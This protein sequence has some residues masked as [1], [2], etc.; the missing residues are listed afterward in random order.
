[1]TPMTQ[2]I[3]L[4]TFAI[5][6]GF[7]AQAA[8]PE[9]TGGKRG[10]ERPSFE[11]LDANK[12]GQLTQDELMAPMTARFGTMDTNGDGELSSDE[13][14]A[15]G[16][17]RAKRRADKMIERLDADKNGTISADEMKTRMSEGRRGK[18]FERLDA[19]DNG[20]ISA[21]EFA[22]IEKRMGKKGGKHGKRKMSDGE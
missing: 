17:E 4:T 13:I 1:M 5:L 11:Q 19:D 21:E 3:G 15:A 8:T 14:A 18:M 2:R 6:V 7:A 20:T 12:D 22:K 9:T 10:G 16:N